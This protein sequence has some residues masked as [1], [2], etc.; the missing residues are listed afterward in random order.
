MIRHTVIF[1]CKP[2]TPQQS[3]S[4]AIENAKHLL[5]G[6][7]GVRSFTIG[8]DLGLQPGKSGEMAVVADFDSVDDLKTYLDDKVHQDYIKDN[9]ASIVDTRISVQF[10]I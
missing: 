3:I 10:E 1:T 6:I 2:G 5:P 8:R 9:L 4:E 7:P